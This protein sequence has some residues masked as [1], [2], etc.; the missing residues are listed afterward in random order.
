MMTKTFVLRAI[1]KYPQIPTNLRYAYLYADDYHSN[2]EYGYLD[3]QAYRR[4][5]LDSLPEGWGELGAMFN[6]DLEPVGEPRREFWR[7]L[8]RLMD[9]LSDERL[10]KL[11]TEESL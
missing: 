4:I 3:P 5:S 8:Y 11:D 2:P 9:A 1:D 6:E 7:P 10:R